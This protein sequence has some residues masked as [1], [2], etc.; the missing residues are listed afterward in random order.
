MKK[1]KLLMI[2]FMALTLLSCQKELVVDTK[3]T[4]STN[5][6]EENGYL[7]AG[8]R[9]AEPFTKFDAVGDR[10]LLED[11]MYNDAGV[12]LNGKDLPNTGPRVVY[13]V[14]SF[15]PG[16]FNAM[17]ADLERRHW[18]IA[19][20]SYLLALSK[21]YSGVWNNNIFWNLYC[22]DLPSKINFG[23]GDEPAVASLGSIWYNPTNNSPYNASLRFQTFSQIQ[24]GVTILAYK[25]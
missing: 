25:E 7:W 15:T 20:L 10:I 11:S 2:T 4:S 21:E 6:V 8:W 16:S 19:P 1:T 12:K 22:L 9:I 3:I 14:Q 24:V 23:A 18:K 5:Q 13:A 17:K